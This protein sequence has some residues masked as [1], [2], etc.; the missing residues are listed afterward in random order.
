MK[1]IWNEKEIIPK[2]FCSNYFFKFEINFTFLS[3]VIV[4]IKKGVFFSFLPMLWAVIMK[5]KSNWHIMGSWH[6]CLLLLL[7]LFYYNYLSIGGEYLVRGRRGLSCFIESTCTL[8]TW[9]IKQALWSG[10][11]WQWQDILFEL[12]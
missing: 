3:Y 11:Q 12:I 2:D 9:Y 8:Y 1:T 7:T 4:F 6:I 5:L 10:C